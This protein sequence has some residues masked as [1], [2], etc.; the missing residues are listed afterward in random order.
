[1]LNLHMLQAY[2]AMTNEPYACLRL[3]LRRT[4]KAQVMTMYVLMRFLHGFDPF[5]G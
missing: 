2:A 1:M 4:W 5:M 3:R